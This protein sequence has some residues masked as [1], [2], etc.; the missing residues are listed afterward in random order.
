[1]SLLPSA[2]SVSDAFAVY[3]LSHEASKH[4]TKT[5]VHYRT[6][7]TPF[8]TWLSDQN[9]NFLHEIRPNHIRF[10]I[11]ERSEGLSQT[12]VN[13]A[14]RAI[15]AFFN[16]CVS[17][18]WVEQTPM[19]GVKMPKLPKS[20]PTVLSVE[21]VKSL[22]S[23]AKTERDKAIFLVLLDTGM[24][25]SELCNL[26]AKDIDIR[27]GTI[28]VRQGKG[29][30]DRVCFV[31]AKTVKAIL[32]YYAARGVPSGN[33]FIWVSEKAG[34]H[35]T[36]SGLAQMLQDYERDL[37]FKCNAH[38]LRRTFATTCLRS[39]MNIFT[40][41]KLMGHEDLTVLR[42]YLVLLDDDLHDAHRRYGV[43]D[44]L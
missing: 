18:S 6:Q 20:V 33:D 16:F 42:S 40:L 31:G 28:W 29:N 37:G 5:V 1:M 23:A 44:N 36:Y 41:Q 4:S 34:G 43:V 2:F 27:T 11:V 35:F 26:C 21:E 9:I 30:K 19:K 15:R 13:T 22:I 17:E 14:A 3:I 8:V 38:R 12:S 25:A 10:F 7:L 39:G 24:R 32:R